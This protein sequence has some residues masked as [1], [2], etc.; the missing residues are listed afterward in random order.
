[1]NLS[2]KI[3]IV[4]ISVLLLSFSSAPPKKSKSKS[5]SKPKAT[6]T[7]FAKSL[8]PEPTTHCTIE[9]SETDTSKTIR[10]RLGDTLCVVLGSTPGTGFSWQN[11]SA[12]TT[13]FTPLGKPEQIQAKNASKDMTGSPEKTIWHFK[14]VRE[15]KG[16]IRLLY[17]RSWETEKSAARI[18]ERN[19]IVGGL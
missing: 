19:I 15:G 9:I 7:Q 14:A 3:L 8:Y 10:L 17:R 4:I 12:D 16:V 18:F 5:K 13:A 2:H 6:A 1:M 11:A